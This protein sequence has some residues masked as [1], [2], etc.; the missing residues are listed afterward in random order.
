MGIISSVLTAIVDKL[1]SAGIAWLQ[2]LQ[3][4][5]ADRIQGMK[6]QHAADVEATVKEATDN[7]II[8]DQVKAAPISSIDADLERVRRDAAAGRK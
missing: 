6:E 8:Q 7:A 2:A 1:I 3:Q 5:R 4:R